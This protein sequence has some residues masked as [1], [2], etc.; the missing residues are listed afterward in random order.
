L[1][2]AISSTWA[3][4]LEAAGHITCHVPSHCQAS[5][6]F[7]GAG[8]STISFGSRHHRL[9][10]LELPTLSS[11]LHADLRHS[12]PPSFVPLHRSPLVAVAM[13]IANELTS[14]PSYL[15]KECHR[16]MIY[17]AKSRPPNTLSPV[18]RT[19][20]VEPC[21]KES[22]STAQRHRRL[23]ITRVPVTP[24]PRFPLCRCRLART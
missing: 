18:R 10:W 4:Q 16:A 17:L 24:S 23:P 22:P 11:S 8:V 19:V 6:A 13:G 2:M 9:H 1:L 5:S 21:Q 7:K 15:G 14:P 3:H 12:S 20:D